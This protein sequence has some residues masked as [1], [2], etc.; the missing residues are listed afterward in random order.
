MRDFYTI[1]KYSIIKIKLP[2][3]SC[4]VKN[5]GWEESVVEYAVGYH[6]T[7]RELLDKLHKSWSHK[8]HHGPWEEKILNTF[9]YGIDV[10]CVVESTIHRKDDCNVWECK[11]RTNDLSVMP[12]HMLILAGKNNN[13]TYYDII[14]YL[15]IKCSQ[16]E[17]LELKT[18]ET[19]TLD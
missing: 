13:N 4:L 7:E 3:P 17:V 5:Y 16:Y 18:L 14:D 19:S 8:Y 2:N 1:G 11:Y 6:L 9:Y 15:K 10:K 12:D